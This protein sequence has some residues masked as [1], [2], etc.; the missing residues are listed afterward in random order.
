MGDAFKRAVITARL[1]GS[2]HRRVEAPLGSPP[3]VHR[4]EHEDVRVGGEPD[5]PSTGV[6]DAAHLTVRT[7][8]APSTL[9]FFDASLRLHG[10]FS[11]T[12]YDNYAA[13]GPHRT[14]GEPVRHA[15]V[16]DAVAVTPAG[17][18]VTV[19]LTA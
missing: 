4:A 5:P 14:K 13:G 19:A 11:G 10:E 15:Y 17:C 12:A 3:R 8:S 1:Q 18:A 16:A 9:E 2:Q 7:E 6:V